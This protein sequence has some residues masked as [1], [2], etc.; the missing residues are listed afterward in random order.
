MYSGASHTCSCCNTRLQST[1]M[2]ARLSMHKCYRWKK[3]PSPIYHYY[4]GICY[5]I[6][7]LQKWATRATQKPNLWN[8]KI[9]Q[10]R[11]GIKNK[12]KKKKKKWSL[13]FTIIAHLILYNLIFSFNQLVQCKIWR[14]VVTVDDIIF[15]KINYSIFEVEIYNILNRWLHLQGQLFFLIWYNI[16]IFYDQRN[17]IKYRKR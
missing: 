6:M 4:V 11:V 13:Q 5:R 10:G 7:H 2:P 9:S 1:L 3:K 14:C 16:S 15:S 12:F 8:F 17:K